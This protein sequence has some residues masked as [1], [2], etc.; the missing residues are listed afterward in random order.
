MKKIVLI[1]L[2]LL[3]SNA[4]YAQENEINLL[5]NKAAKSV[6]KYVATFKNLSAEEKKDFK[7]YKK[8]GS[9]DESRII[10]STLIIYQPENSQA[11]YEF[12]NPLE[13][14]GKSVAKSDEKI[15]DFFEKLVKVKTDNKILNKIR[16]E[17]EQYD[18][19]FRSYGVTLNPITP[20]F[21]LAPFFEFKVVSREKIE[22][23]EVIVIQYVQTKPTLL[24][25]VNATEEEKK[26][27][28][29]IEFNGLISNKFRPTNPRMSGKI[30]LDAET[31][32]VWRNNFKISINPTALSHAV[33]FQENDYQY[34]SSPFGILVPKSARNISYK[35]EGDSDKNL[36]AY[37]LADRFF[38]YSNFESVA[39]EIKKY[40]VV[41]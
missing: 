12:R 27:E 30:W 8:D 10:K 19:Y 38:E 17:S 34:Q 14:N 33:E 40:E 20:F 13:F 15:G 28:S 37:K 18:G 16:D 5:F 11:T 21:A 26:A 4:I 24:Y 23:R 29:I 25:K 1:F 7:Y 32:Q 9:I 22:G 2:I 39:A 41:K 6:V 35:I 36:K 31:G 3:I